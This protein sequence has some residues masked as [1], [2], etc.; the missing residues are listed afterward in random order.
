[1]P[2]AVNALE[3]TGVAVTVSTRVALPVPAA[4]VAPNV[5]FVCPAVVGIPEITPVVVLTVS[6]AGNPVALKLVWLLVATI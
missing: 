6:P 4:L 3:I 1:M 5:M 2:L